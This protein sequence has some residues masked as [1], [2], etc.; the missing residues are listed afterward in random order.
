V[1]LS[2]KESLENRGVN[3]LRFLMLSLMSVPAR[4]AASGT[5]SASAAGRPDLGVKREKH[6]RVDHAA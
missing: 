1:I 6:L 3:A 4:N 5:D 2:I